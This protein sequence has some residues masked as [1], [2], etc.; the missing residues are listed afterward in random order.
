MSPLRSMLVTIAALSAVDAFSPSMPSTRFSTSLDAAEIQFCKGLEEKVV[1][2]I[3]LT[4]AKDGSS[5][6]AT[7]NFANPN[8]FDASTASEGEITGMFLV[9]DEGEMTTSDVNARFINGK[10]QS[11]ESTL[12]M[13][14]PEEWDRFMRFMERYAEAN[15][16]GFNK[17]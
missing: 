17:A 15:E 5:G 2:D 6:I 1:P 9:D 14:S 10:P 8:V 12:V 7:F 16:L 13:T 3:K 11:I 4:R